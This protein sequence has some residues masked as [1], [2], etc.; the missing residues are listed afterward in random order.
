MDASE[1]PDL[2]HQDWKRERFILPVVNAKGLPLRVEVARYL[3]GTPCCT[4]YADSTSMRSRILLTHAVGFSK[5]LWEPIITRLFSLQD[6]DKFIRNKGPRVHIHEIWTV[7]CPNQGRSAAL[8]D[9]VLLDGDHILTSNHYADAILTL[10]TSDVLHLHSRSLNIPLIAV[11]HSY[12]STALSLAYSRSPSHP[13]FEKLVMIEPPMLSRGLLDK[14]PDYIPQL[15]E[16]T[17]R[18]RDK[19]ISRGNAYSSMIT[20]QPYKGWDAQVVRI[21]VDHCL[22]DAPSMPHLPSA[23]KTVTLSC[24][25]PQEMACYSLSEGFQCLDILPSICATIPVH[26]IFGS[27]RDLAHPEIQ[28]S[29]VDAKQGRR[30]V[31]VTSVEQGGHFVPFQRPESCA[32]AIWNALCDPR[33]PNRAPKL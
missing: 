20:R 27:I 12:G 10:M 28:A 3:P 15:V 13:L 19:W 4:R 30:M 23:L 1:Q 18:R 33:G 14:Y 31:T 25:V 17:R 24:A 11:G 22:R 5:E 8:N 16:R 21:Y 32:K 7:D 2:K 26:T 9:N 6:T 29:I